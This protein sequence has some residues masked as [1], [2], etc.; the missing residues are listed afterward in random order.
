[1][2]RSPIVVGHVVLSLQAGGL[3]NGV[4]NVIN[5]LDK[6]EFRSVVFC[7]QVAGEFAQRIAD[8]DVKV[9]SFG[10][11]GG[12]NPGLIWRLARSLKKENVA[13]V[14]TRNPEAFFYG[15]VAARIAGVKGLIH[16]E[17]GRDFP[18][19]W[20]RM[21]LQRVLSRR[22]NAI[23]TMSEDLKCKLITYV[24][25]PPQS[26]SV[27]Y[28][29][30]GDEFFEIA[31]SAAK[32]RS[33][34]L[35]DGHFVVGSIGRLAEVKN[36]AMLIEGV[37]RLQK[38][39]VNVAFLLVGDGPLRAPLEAL[40]MKLLKPGS[41]YF[42]GFQNDI[43]PY[44]AAMDIFAL[45]SLNEGISN[46]LLEAMAAKRAVVVT[47]VGGNLEIVKDQVN[48]CMVDS[49]DVVGLANA[50]GRYIQERGFREATAEAGRAYVRDR[51][52]MVSMVRQYE[53]LYSLA[54]ER[55]RNAQAT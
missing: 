44:L 42:A 13:V 51:H 36:Q 26:I 43:R 10:L 11:K 18:D 7:L 20:H 4:V 32:D 29:G 47:K 41:Y 24:K 38:Q 23:F 21:L 12:N 8:P 14:H 16:S 53:E 22:A 35:P 19:K 1:M 37:A 45:T 2:M 31:R 28:N 34:G 5:R 46:T 33:I 50:L 30:V 40:A 15:A 6:N 55:T 27:I 3:E 48:G 54:A 52:S 39:G 25:I 49:G 17:H 9:Y